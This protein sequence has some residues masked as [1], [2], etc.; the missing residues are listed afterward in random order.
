MIKDL[1]NDSDPLQ[2]DGSSFMFGLGFVRENELAGIDDTYL[3]VSM[4][5]IRG[6]S[7]SNFNQITINLNKRQFARKINFDYEYFKIF[8]C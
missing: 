7:I 4:A 8:V 1:Y 2:L 5:Y 3:T 6:T